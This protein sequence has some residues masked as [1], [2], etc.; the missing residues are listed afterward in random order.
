M[1]A[2]T[3]EQWKKFLQW[4]KEHHSSDKDVTQN[5]KFIQKVFDEFLYLAAHMNK[6]IRR[7]EGMNKERNNLIITPGQ[8]GF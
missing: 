8:M 4:Y 2:E 1:S 7:L 6:D 5:M 3:D